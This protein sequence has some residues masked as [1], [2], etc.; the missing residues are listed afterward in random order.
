MADPVYIF[1]FTHSYPPY[2]V[3]ESAAFPAKKAAELFAAQLGTLS[4]DDQVTLAVE[5]AE[6]QAAKPLQPVTV[7]TIVNPDGTISVM[8]PPGLPNYGV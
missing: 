2:V 8:L 1:N 5:I 7:T 3:G 4:S 6:A